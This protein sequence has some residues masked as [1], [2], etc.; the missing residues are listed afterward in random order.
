M[1]TGR[2][3]GTG[4][5]TASE[6]LSQGA[7]TGRWS[8]RYVAALIAVFLAGIAL[9]VALFPSVG[10]KGDIDQFVVWVQHI[11]VN[12]L[13]NAY[14]QNLTFGPVMAYIW[15][16]LAFL[17]PAFRTATD[18]SDPWIRSLMKVP[19]SLAD[20]GLAGLMVY[21]FRS[22]PFWAVVTAAIVL[23]HPAVWDV[24]AWWGQYESIYVLT[25]LAALV[26]ALN[27]RTGL[28]AAALALAVM[29]K[30][31]ALPFLLP[32]AA[33]FWVHGGWREIARTA[34]IGLAVIIVLWLPFAAAG[35][36][37]DYLHNLAVYQN[38][39]FPILSLQAWNIWW[40]VQ[41]AAVE[42]YAGDQ[43]TVLGPIT[44]RHIGFILTGLLSLIVALL[45]LRDPRP[46]TLILGLAASTLIWFGFLTQ[47]HER[48][49]YGALIF[50]LLLIPERRIAWLYVAF[51][52]VFTLDLLS[53]APPSP[54]FRT[55]LPFGGVVSVV[56]AIAMIAITFLTV[57][58]MTSRGSGGDSERD[59]RVAVDEGAASV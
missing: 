15:G 16:V 8:G 44:L 57:T 43:V 51:G 26:F 25:A 52:V 3:S 24:S 50:L 22:T 34:T 53:A 9:R 6:P 35:G 28:A 42:G 55:L 38:E 4:R 37:G 32:F 40:L 13:G 46:R 30:P 47:M 41:V 2:P 18:S 59:H 45:I 27:G 36:P 12:G 14:D 5:R 29:T 58:W 39:I 21:A 17:E 1:S 49:A 23:L 56:G 33:W 20:L 54:I 31:Q 19:A 48:Y 10:L 11:A 7:T